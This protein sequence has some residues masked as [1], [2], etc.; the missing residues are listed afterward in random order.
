MKMPYLCVALTVT[1]AACSFDYDLNEEAANGPDIIMRDIDYVRMV[2][3]NPFVQFKAEEARQYAKNHS[4][5]MD[6]FSFE[7]FNSIPSGSEQKPEV[8]VRG[9]GV[10]AK[11]QTDTGNVNIS[12]GVSIDVLS[13]EISIKT[14]TLIWQ[15]EERLLKAPEYV[16]LSKSD[17]TKI[18]GRNFTAD[19]R[20][21][22]W[23][24]ESDI[25]GEIVEAE[26][27]SIE[28]TAAG[29]ET[30]IES[31]EAPAAGLENR[32]EGIADY[33]FSACP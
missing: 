2:N 18:S 5:E 32:V 26:D 23:Q 28:E 14:P 16:E 8:N 22:S 7:Q 1:F 4:M 6:T 12:G 25:K 33:R 21:R 24:F 31:I 9:E 30:N 17:G 10:S 15:N 29:L 11:I 3:A 13:E 19:T 20:K 27:E